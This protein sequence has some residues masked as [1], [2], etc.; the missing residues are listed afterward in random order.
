MLGC[1]ERKGVEKI[2]AVKKNRERILLVMHSWK[3]KNVLKTQ[4]LFRP[5]N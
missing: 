2:K 1:K 3:L 5:L 4:E